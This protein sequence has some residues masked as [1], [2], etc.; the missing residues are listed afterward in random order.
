[1]AEIP[2]IDIGPL[3]ARSA[4]AADVAS[5]IGSAR[6]ETGF[7]DIIGHGVAS[8]LVDTVFSMSRYLFGPPPASPS[9]ATARSK[10][11]TSRPQLV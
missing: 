11:A 3:V 4:R 8:E 10:S 2:I 6:R 5:A 7:F 1:M 9:V